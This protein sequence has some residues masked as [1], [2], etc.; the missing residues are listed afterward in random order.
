M[1]NRFGVDEAGSGIKYVHD[2][3]RNLIKFKDKS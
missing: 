1:Q 3:N 2:K